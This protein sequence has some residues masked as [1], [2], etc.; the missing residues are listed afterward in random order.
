MRKR[1][2]KA[3]SK[4]SALERVQKDDS[5]AN[6][7]DEP[8]SHNAGASFGGRNE[9]R[10]K[11]HS[12]WI[13]CR[14]V[15]EAFMTQLITISVKRLTS[16]GFHLR[17]NYQWLEEENKER[18]KKPTRGEG[19]LCDFVTTDQRDCSDR[20]ILASSRGGKEVVRHGRIELDSHVDTIVF[21]KKCVVLNYT[22]QEYD[23]LPYTDI[24]DSIK[25]VL[26]AKAGTA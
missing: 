5:E 20:K 13:F 18:E 9:K 25:I 23:V 3:N 24:Y 12:S 7:D 22:G 1:L 15:L 17:F 26:I 16:F 10:N 11:K 4:I 19:W 14:S 8:A 6:S 21:G 2:K